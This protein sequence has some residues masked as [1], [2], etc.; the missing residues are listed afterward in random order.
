MP[1]PYDLLSNPRRFRNLKIAAILALI[2]LVV[3]SIMFRHLESRSTAVAPTPS[4]TQIGPP[5]PDLVAP[6]ALTPSAPVE[7]FG[8]SIHIALEAVDAF[9]RND[10]A[11]F[12]EIASPGIVSD[13]N[14]APERQA[15][16]KII[17]SPRLI[18]PGPT[19]QTV[20]VS[21]TGGALILTMVIDR[22]DGPARWVVDDMKYDRP[23]G[24]A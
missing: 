1:S 6:K 16:Q 24:A 21:T 9:L 18:E 14:Q 11:R 4:A 5:N 2:L 15:G 20:R 23:A 3:G 22:K 13:V 19:Q 17:G 7:D 8:S 10:S 12:A